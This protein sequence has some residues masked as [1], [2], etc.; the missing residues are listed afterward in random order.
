MRNTKIFNTI[1]FDTNFNDIDIYNTPITNSLFYKCRFTNKNTNIYG[2][3]RKRESI[4][5]I[6]NSD[7]NVTLKEATFF[8]N[9]TE[10]KLT[11]K[12]NDLNGTVFKNV[13]FDNIKFVN[14][15]FNGAIF[16]K[17]TFKNCIFT[18]SN[19]FIKENSEVIK[20]LSINLSNTTYE[21]SNIVFVYNKKI[22]FKVKNDSINQK[23]LVYESRK[24]IAC[25]KK[26]QKN[27]IKQF[28]LLEYNQ[29]IIDLKNYIKS[30]CINKELNYEIR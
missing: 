3:I 11:V 21:D 30:N 29:E 27:I 15:T 2:E 5:E 17:T 19:L 1:F 22:K 18:F 9:K 4:L 14:T 8:V 7:N 16:K 13:V 26:N 20:Q 12:F 10:E 28:E 23:K 6:K 24:H 25:Q